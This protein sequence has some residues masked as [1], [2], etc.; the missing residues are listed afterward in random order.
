MQAGEK[1]KVSFEGMMGDTW[2]EVDVTMDDKGKGSYEVCEYD[3]HEDLTYHAEG[4]ISVDTETN[5]L[6]DYDGCFQLHE[7]VVEYL[8][9]WGIRAE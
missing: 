2:V 3:R 4:I 8:E 1:H 7:K 6:E 5:E 9:S